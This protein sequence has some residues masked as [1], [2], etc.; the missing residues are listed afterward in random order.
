MPRPKRQTALNFRSCKA[1]ALKIAES[2][3]RSISIPNTPKGIL[4]LGPRSSQ[5]EPFDSV[6]SEPANP[7]NRPEHQ[8]FR[9]YDHLVEPHILSDR[10]V[11]LVSTRYQPVLELTRWL[12]E[13]GGEVATTNALDLA[14]QAISEAPDR[15][16]LLA[17]LMDGLEA[18]AAIVE[19]LLLLR[20]IKPD[21]P[22]ILVSEE[23]KRHDYSTD[24]MLICD[25]SLRAPVSQTALQL[26]VAQS[27]SNNLQFANKR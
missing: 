27:I 13:L 4:K 24:R 2:I 19:T 26:A 7:P 16:G 21:L 17:V 25:V 3:V 11:L 22:V 8:E 1:A 14:V 23:F 12:E 10:P 15:W 9:K 5:W 20:S 6:V 18:S